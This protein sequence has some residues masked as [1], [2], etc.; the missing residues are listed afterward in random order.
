MILL[1]PLR[2]FAFPSLV[3]VDAERTE[4]C[5]MKT[6]IAVTC[7]LLS[8]TVNKPSEE[9]CARKDFLAVSSEINHEL[10]FSF[11]TSPCPHFV[12]LKATS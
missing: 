9:A 8:L 7:L 5:M 12:V 2:G 3:Q 10:C 6:Q 11:F 1:S 4:S